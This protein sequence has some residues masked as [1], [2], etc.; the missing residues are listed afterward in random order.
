MLGVFVPVSTKANRFTAPVGHASQ[1]VDPEDHA[2]LADALLL[3]VGP[4][5]FQEAGPYPEV[6]FPCL[7]WV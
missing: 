5:P 4:F 6:A 1:E 2:F 7:A 3:V